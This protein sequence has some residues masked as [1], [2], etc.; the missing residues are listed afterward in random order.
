MVKVVKNP[1]ENNLSLVRRFSTK[2]KMSGVLLEARKRLF[3]EKKLNKRARKEKALR[4]LRKIEEA[5]EK[6]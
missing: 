3:R 4:R 2:L 1:N 5:R 6:I